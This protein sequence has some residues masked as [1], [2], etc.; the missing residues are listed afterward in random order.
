MK[1]EAH[2]QRTLGAQVSFEKSLRKSKREK[3]R[4][5]ECSCSSVAR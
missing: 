4:R 5:N 1:Q 2:F 3:S